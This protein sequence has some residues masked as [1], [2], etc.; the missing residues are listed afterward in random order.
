M[1]VSAAARFT[2]PSART[3][4][5]GCFSQ[6]ILKLPIERC[7]CAPHYLLASTAVSPI[8]GSLSDIYGRRVTLMTAIGIFFM[9][10]IV[11]ALAPTMPWLIA[12]RLL[13]GLGCGGII[14]LVQT[15]LSDVVMPRD[16]GKYQAYFG[17]VWISVGFGG[18]VL[19]GFIAEYLHWTVIF[20]IN[21]PL[22][23]LTIAMLV[24][25]MKKVPVH[26]R[27]RRVDIA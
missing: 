21:L 25:N 5:S 12:G 17:M 15:T 22:V 16:R 14:P 24:P 2:M 10:S 8:F 7:D 19:G 4:G 3:T 18:P 20:W 26:I 6:P 11:R 9:G 27:P 23:A 13:Q 1:L